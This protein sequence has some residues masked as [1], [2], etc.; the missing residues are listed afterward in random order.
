[1]ELQLWD[2]TMI[3]YHGQPEG[4]VILYYQIQSEDADV[5]DYSTEM[6]MPMYDNLY[7]KKFVL[8]SNEKLKY[9]F[10]ETIDGNTYQSEKKRLVKREGAG[11]AGRYG[12]LNQILQSSG[13]ER[14]KRMRAYAAEDKMA[15]EFFKQY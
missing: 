5:L 3:E 2:K 12:R 6:L 4:C 15:N 9:Y 10:K 11:T 14:S 7:V 1:M 13:E 8:Y